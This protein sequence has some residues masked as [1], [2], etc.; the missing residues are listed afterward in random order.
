[1]LNVDF[2]RIIELIE[3][4]KNNAHRK[5]NEEMILLYLEVGKYLFNLQQE[6]NY[7][8]KITTNAA[9]FMKI[10]IQTLKGLQREILKE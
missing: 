10:I 2:N 5:V 8:E 1:M 6:S 7:G 9:N 3:R 4:R